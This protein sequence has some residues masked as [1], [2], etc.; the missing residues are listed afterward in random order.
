MFEKQRTLDAVET[1]LLHFLY[2]YFSLPPN[3]ATG[4]QCAAFLFILKNIFSHHTHQQF[5]SLR[6]QLL[7]S[8]ILQMSDV[9]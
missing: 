6:F 2:I 3:E 8:K 4:L 5:V 9:P 1:S 7:H